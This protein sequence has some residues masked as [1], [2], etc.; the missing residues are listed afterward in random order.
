MTTTTPNAI[1]PGVYEGMSFAEYH[2][3]PAASDSQLTQLLRSPAHLRA[4]LDSERI[5][6]P[7]M[8][9]GTAVHAA[10]LEPDAFDRLYSVLPDPDPEIYRNKDGS[11]SRN[12]ASTAAYKAAVLDVHD[13]H[14][15]GVCLDPIEYAACHG[16]WQSVLAHPAAAR[17]LGAATKRELSIVWDDPLTGVRCKARLDAYAPGLGGG[18][19]ADLKTAIE[20][21]PVGFERAVLHWGYHRKAWFYLRGARAVGLEAQHF[22]II[23]V[24]KAPPYAVA[25]YRVDDAVLAYIEDHMTALLRLYEAC[26]ASDHWPGY[27]D[28]VQD[29]GVPDWGWRVID[30]QTTSALLQLSRVIDQ[31]KRTS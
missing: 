11:E 26:R 27:P 12:V 3:I 20:G 22:P 6:T 30:D 21:G 17:I 10:L 19:I 14:P 2:R 7:A 4:Y 28:D 18:T 5:E 1:E 9:L 31:R 24:E 15:G 16:M 8:R 13:E 25:V 29:I 23:A